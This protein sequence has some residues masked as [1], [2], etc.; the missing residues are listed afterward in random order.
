MF[1]DPTGMIAN[2]IYDPDG[3]FLG[4]DDKGL[5]GKAIVMNKENFTQGMSNED[6]LSH[7]LGKKGLS[8]SEAQSS[9][10]SHYNGLKDRPDYD[11]YLTLNE[12]NDWYRNGNG[13][14]LY[15]DSSKIDLS[16]QNISNF[17]VGESKYINFASPSNAN[18]AT[19]LVYGTIK[20]TMLDKNGSTKLGGEGGKL[21]TYDFDYKPNRTG[22]NIATWI[23]E[24]VAGQGNG[25]DI[26][27]YGRAKLQNKP[28]QSNP[29]PRLY[30]GP[31]Y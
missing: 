20:L 6:A 11:G 25:F 23:G 28:I 30:Q 8:S 9:L 3:N 22:R 27:T 14:P 13:E 17:K 31:K 7:N 10:Y 4:T 18:V 5:Q 16:P 29:K 26:F 21:D 12:A 1:T 15:V 19:G 24:Q 2:P